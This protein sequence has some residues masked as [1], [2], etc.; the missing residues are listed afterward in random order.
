MS[1][2]IS[3]GGGGGADGG[4][5][6]GRR[7]ATLWPRQNQVRSSINLSSFDSDHCCSSGCGNHDGG[8]GGCGR[9][10]DGHVSLHGETNSG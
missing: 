9:G 10:S 8:G 2:S 6:G 7:S 5:C 4:G 3:L 1:F